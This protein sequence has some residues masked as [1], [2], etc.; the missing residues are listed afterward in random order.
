ME[1]NA[2]DPDLASHLGHRDIVLANRFLCHMYPGEAESCL[3]NK[4]KLIKP[5]G[6]LFVTG[7]DLDVRKKVMAHSDFKPVS[8][9][10]QE[11]HYAGLT[12]L[13]GWPWRY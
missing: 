1:G 3:K 11:I 7:I 13:H 8:T 5:G 12:L 4:I 6:Y 9:H 2:C 10:L